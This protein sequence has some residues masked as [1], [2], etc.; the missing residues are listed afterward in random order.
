MKQHKDITSLQAF[1]KEIFGPSMTFQTSTWQAVDRPF[2]PH[3]S[4]A[5]RGSNGRLQGQQQHGTGG[6]R[7]EG[8]HHGL[9]VQTTKPVAQVASFLSL[10]FTN[11]YHK[12]R[13]FL[14]AAEFHIQMDVSSKKLCCHLDYIVSRCFTVP[15]PIFTTTGLALVLAHAAHDLQH[16]AVEAVGDLLG[17]HLQGGQGR[18]KDEDLLI[19]LQD[20]PQ[21]LLLWEEDQICSIKLSSSV[22][23]NE[24][25][26]K[27]QVVPGQ[28]GGS[29]L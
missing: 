10:Y 18:A 17:E 13:S 22:F 29:F 26:K 5:V 6:I 14:I 24:R 3:R 11:L 28:A 4:S 8:I 7:L 16:F 19:A 21:Q 27:L 15:P 20:A 2:S 12:T 1:V 25:E 23:L 9:G